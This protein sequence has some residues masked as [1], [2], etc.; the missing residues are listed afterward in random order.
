[1]IE[2]KTRIYKNVDMY[3]CAGKYVLDYAKSGSKLVCDLK[4]TCCATSYQRKS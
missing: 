1:M 2:L 4:K 3:K